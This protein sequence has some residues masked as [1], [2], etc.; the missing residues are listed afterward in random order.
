MTTAE[1]IAVM[2]AYKD[3]K[4]IECADKG[5]TNWKKLPNPVWNWDRFDYRV[6][7]ESNIRPYEN[8][9]EFMKA[10]K[11][12]GPYYT[13]KKDINRGRVYTHPGNVYDYAFGTNKGILCSFKEFA[14]GYEWA[15]GTP[16]GIVEEE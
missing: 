11:E 14:I 10:M 1:M 13:K 5:G 9:Q 15:D 4:S 3:G 7:P 8:A 16:C 6:K 12:H 2:Q